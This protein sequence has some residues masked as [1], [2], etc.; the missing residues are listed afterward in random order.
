[1]QA[2]GGMLNVMATAAQTK[3]IGKVG[4]V[5]IST[6]PLLQSK[7]GTFFGEEV[8]RVLNERPRVAS[9]SGRTTPLPLLREQS[10]EN[11]EDL[12]RGT[13]GWISPAHASRRR[14]VRNLRSTSDGN[15]ASSLPTRASI[16]T[17]SSF[18]SLTSE[19]SNGEQ[20]GREEGEP[21]GSWTAN[22]TRRPSEMV[23]T[24]S[25]LP[26]D[27][28]S[29][30]MEVEDGTAGTTADSTNS[31]PLDLEAIASESL[32]S[33]KSK[34]KE[35]EKLSPASPRIDRIL[36]DLGP[37]SSA[38][39]KTKGKLPV[40]LEP[41]P[42]NIKANTIN[43]INRFA[44]TPPRLPREGSPSV[45]TNIGP[46]HDL[47]VMN[48]AT[49]EAEPRISTDG[50]QHGNGPPPPLEPDVDYRSSTS[51]PQGH[52]R[53]GSL[54]DKARRLSRELVRAIKKPKWRMTMNK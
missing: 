49:S 24:V 31:P 7:V 10:S 52:K 1:M 41:E 25:E 38:S 39:E 28:Y 50:L 9:V 37:S 36:W 48:P 27:D 23:V 22:T 29:E 53:K 40:I 54:R 2:F 15:G 12:H 17:D 51:N 32:P 34:G 35:P 11:R 46:L 16:P 47:Y 19:N 5:R 26:G 33:E 13:G 30:E 6:G 4:V 3:A 21:R 14:D 42:S 8:Q 18:K 20:I 43:F 44:E 45:P